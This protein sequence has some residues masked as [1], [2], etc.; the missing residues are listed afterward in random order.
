MTGVPEPQSSASEIFSPVAPTTPMA[1][2][3][4]TGSQSDVQRPWLETEV[5]PRLGQRALQPLNTDQHFAV[6]VHQRKKSH[7]SDRR[8]Q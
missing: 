5:D 7:C 2:A 6:G 3:G 4:G 8:K 1:G